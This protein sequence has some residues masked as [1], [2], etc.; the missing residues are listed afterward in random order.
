MTNRLT[1]GLLASSIWSALL[2]IVIPGS[3]KI[4][5]GRANR[6]KHGPLCHSFSHEGGIAFVCSRRDSGQALVWRGRR[7]S[8]HHR[9]MTM[10]SEIKSWSPSLSLRKTIMK[11]LMT[12]RGGNLANS[13]SRE[14][15]YPTRE[16][17]NTST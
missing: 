17:S 11:A 1:P 2:I 15:L 7:G 13:R 6:R 8:R 4:R 9:I 3:S 10:V 16:P 5:S 14:R 12:K